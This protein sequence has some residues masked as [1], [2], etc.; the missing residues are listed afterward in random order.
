V[1]VEIEDLDHHGRG[2]GRLAGKVVFVEGALPG[3]RVLYRRRRRRR[4]FDEGEALEILS[5]SPERVAPRCPHFAR[6]GGCALQHLAPA[7]QLE[8]KQAKLLDALRSVADLAPERV[9]EPI[10][11]APWGY[12]RR[13]RLGVKHVPAK[14]GALVGF[15]ERHSP[16][17]IAEIDGCEILEASIGRR[18]GALRALIGSLQAR[19]RIPQIEF[20]AGDSGACLVVRHLDALG[21]AD[22]QALAAFA[23]EQRLALMLQPGG[24]QS[25]EPLVPPAAPAL[26]YELPAHGLRLEFAPTDFVQ[27]NAAANRAL[28][29]RALALLETGPGDRVLDLYCGIGNFTLAIARHAGAVTGCEGAAGLVARARANAAAN[30]IDNATFETADLDDPE[31]VA[32][33]LAAGWDLLLLDPPRAGAAT[34]C[35]T[36]AEPYPRRIVYVSCNPGT[37]ARDAAT[38]CAA[39]GYRLEAAGVVDMFP[40]TRHV[41]SIAAFRRG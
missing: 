37:L 38:L 4:R 14:G 23:H 17:K 32:G 5:P 24:P 22:R 18:I 40:H 33:C 25:L 1:V 19:A 28:V 9:L 27:V 31:A 20:A 26:A 34:L 8:H 11:A 16:G 13:A 12:R 3:E 6:C 15:R 30:G 10:S 2:V 39:H 36:L 7:A 35:A 41:E 29:D 21:A